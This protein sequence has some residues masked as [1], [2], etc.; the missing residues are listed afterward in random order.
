M[1]DKSITRTVLAVTL[2]SFC[3]LGSCLDVREYN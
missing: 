2:P 3:N 1:W